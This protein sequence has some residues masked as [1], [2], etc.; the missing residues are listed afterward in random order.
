MKVLAQICT[1]N[2]EDVGEFALQAILG[3]THPLDEILI[4]DNA[5]TDGTLA[6]LHELETHEPGDG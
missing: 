3:Q 5:S 1:L 2:D 6:N 4:V